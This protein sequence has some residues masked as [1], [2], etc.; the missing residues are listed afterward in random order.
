[1]RFTGASLGVAHF[2][3]G[4]SWRTAAHEPR[5]PARSTP[6]ACGEVAETMS[7][8]EYGRAAMTADLIAPAPGVRLF[9]PDV[10]AIIG[11]FSPES[12]HRH[13][14]PGCG[15]TSL[16]GGQGSTNVWLPVPLSTERRRHEIVRP[17]RRRRGLSLI[18][19]DGHPRSGVLPG[20]DVH[21][22]EHGEEEATP[23]PLVHVGVQ[24]RE[25]RA[26][27]AG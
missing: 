14:T 3:H 18:R 21:H 2:E 27:P 1:M 12:S 25:R 10:L 9:A 11:Q 16:P 19:F 22:G 24:D 26:V 7:A 17:R 15:I 8:R 6:T 23:S 13:G 20:Q 5:R 4:S